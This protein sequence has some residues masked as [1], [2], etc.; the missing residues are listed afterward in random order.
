MLYSAKIPL[1]LLVACFISFIS[2][3][4]AEPGTLQQPDIPTTLPS[5]E[6]PRLE[7]TPV[8]YVSEKGWLYVK[9]GKVTLSLTPCAYQYVKFYCMNVRKGPPPILVG[10]DAY[11]EDGF[12]AGDRVFSNLF[13]NYWAEAYTSEHERY[14]SNTLIVRTIEPEPSDQSRSGKTGE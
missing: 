7:L 12:K 8:A 14:F 2:A 13:L 10:I 11:G 3:L 4:A 9:P 5:I 6:M 1:L